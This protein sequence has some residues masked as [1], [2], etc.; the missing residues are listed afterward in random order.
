[1]KGWERGRGSRGDRERDGNRE[2]KGEEAAEETERETVI[3]RG[4]ETGGR[5]RRVKVSRERKPIEREPR[6]PE[7][8][9]P[10]EDP[11]VHLVLWHRPNLDDGHI[12][13]DHVPEIQHDGLILI[14]L[15]DTVMLFKIQLVMELSD[16]LPIILIYQYQFT[17]HIVS[18]RS[19]RST[20]NAYAA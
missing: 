10:L 4:K 11:I 20:R 19:A 13:I 7:I 5:G 8:M 1:M 18:A 15:C 17:P 12:P 6:S 9:R 3:G 16:H 2:G 14:V